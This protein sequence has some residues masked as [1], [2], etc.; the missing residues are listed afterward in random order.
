MPYMVSKPEKFETCQSGG[1]TQGKK[2]LNFDPQNGTTAASILGLLG[3]S[4]SSA[5]KYIEFSTRSCVRDVVLEKDVTKGV[6]IEV[7]G[8]V[9]F[10]FA[11]AYLLSHT[12]QKYVARKENQT[13]R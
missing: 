5:V 4:R 12:K 2:P 1:K 3:R 6:A 7:F 13:I 11:S 9:I 10:L 8:M